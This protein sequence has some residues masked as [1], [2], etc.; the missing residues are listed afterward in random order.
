MSTASTAHAKALSSLIVACLLVTWL[1]WGST[2][3]AIKFML[4]GFPPLFGS[5]TRFLA[6]GSLLLVWVRWRGDAWPT[7]RQWGSAVVIGTLMMGG[8]MGL[9]AVAQTSVGSGLV[10]AFIAVVPMMIALINQCFG[11]RTSALE[12]ASIAVGLGGV[13][14]LTQGNGFQASPQGLLAI[15][16]ACLGWALGSVLSQRG[17]ELAPGAMGF[18]SE[19]LAGGLVLWAISWFVGERPT[20]STEPTVWVAWAYLV[21]FGSLLA[22]SAYMV[23]LQRSSSALA[24][25]YTFV[26][27]VIAMLLGVGVLHEQVSPLEW[28]AVGVVLL[29]VVLMLW[30]GVRKNRA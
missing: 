15:T 9:T 5:A 8:G 7:L 19:M 21:V 13:L 2:Y 10:V 22:F 1:V 6:A 17:L 12:W 3:T 28:S 23:L 20:L 29:G 30:A 16:L 25:S 14:L 18:A 11:V 4:E 24:S 26:N 27:P